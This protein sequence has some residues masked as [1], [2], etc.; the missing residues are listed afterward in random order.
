MIYWIDLC[1][2]FAVGQATA[3]LMLALIV[4]Q[5]YR[6]TWI[7]DGKLIGGICTDNEVGLRNLF[8]S[9]PELKLIS[10]ERLNAES[11]DKHS[12]KKQESLPSE[13]H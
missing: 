13:N 9:I 10:M 7:K 8:A 3:A 4:A 12:A 6:R 5:L 2:W 1:F 11:F